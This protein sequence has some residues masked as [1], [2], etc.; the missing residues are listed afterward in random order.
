MAK[1]TKCLAPV[2]DHCGLPPSKC[3]RLLSPR[4]PAIEQRTS[5]RESFRKSFDIECFFLAWL[6]RPI[7]SDS[8]AMDENLA[9]LVVTVCL[10][11]ALFT[12]AV[13]DMRSFR[14][15]DAF[16]LPLIAV[17]L[18]LVCTLPSVMPEGARFLDHLTGAL[19]GFAFFGLLGEMIYRR[20][21]KEALGLG[22]AKLMGAAGAWLGWQALPSVLLIAALS[23]LAYALIVRH[24]YGTTAVAFGPW[25]GLG[26]IVTWLSAARP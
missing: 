1:R 10:A 19:V 11:M 13:V 22:D 9:W 23:G 26:F 2:G 12:L 15:P 25:I 24:R 7:L 18:A 5:V 17:G 14:I 6:F 8:G 21:G 20:T 3:I 4:T 16:S